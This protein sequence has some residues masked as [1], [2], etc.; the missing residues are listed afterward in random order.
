MYEIDS[1][2]AL[3]NSISKREATPFASHGQLI[4]AMTFLCLL[5]LPLC[6]NHGQ[7]TASERNITD[8]WYVGS[9]ADCDYHDLG[10]ALQVAGG[11]LHPITH[12]EIRIAASSLTGRYSI[13]LDDF[14]EGPTPLE[15]LRIVGGYSACGGS[16]SQTSPRTTLDANGQCCSADH[17]IFTI[18]YDADES[19]AERTVVLENLEMTGG[20]AGE[21]EGGLTFDGGGIRIIGRPGRL[22][23]K[24]INSHVFENQAVISG[25]GGGVYIE[26]TGEEI[27]DDPGNQPPPLLFLDDDSVVTGNV[28]ADL[29]GAI[30]CVDEYDAGAETFALYHVQTGNA[31]IRSNSATHGGGLSLSGCRAV[32]RAGGPYVFDVFNQ[33]FLYSGGV[34]Q[35]SADNRGGGIHAENGAWVVLRGTPHGRWGGVPESAAWIAFNQA[36]RGG[37]L[38]VV[39]EDSTV[40]A[41]DTWFE[42]NTV[43]TDGGS[44]GLGGAIY[45]LNQADVL[46]DRMLL[47]GDDPQDCRMERPT[48]AGIPPRCSGLIGNE[49][50][51]NGAAFYVMNGARIDVRNSF[52]QHN[53]SEGDFGGLSRT[54]NSTGFGGI[55]RAHVRM[56]NTLISGN[57]AEE[58]LIYSGAGGSHELRYSTIAAN[59]LPGSGSL[60]RAFSNDSTRRSLN[61]VLGSILWDEN[62]RPITTGGNEGY[63]FIGCVIGNDDVDDQDNIAPNEY[64]SVIDPEF[65]DSDDGDFGLA[66]TSPA[67]NYCDDSS[68]DFVPPIDHDLDLH[69]RNQI[70]TG[71]ITEPPNPS[72]GRIYDLGAF[73]VI[74]DEVFRDRFETE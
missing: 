35:N 45:A 53:A 18:N 67:I 73:V 5:I 19:D 11:Q 27:V 44:G 46:I 22:G 38:Y 10:T 28:A 49:A 26:T 72:D 62:A 43:A 71:Q 34:L 55:F 15:E 12:L 13:N 23:V 52:V 74:P 39:G 32:I 21:T 64:Y 36:T 33:Q 31:L 69:D 4:A 2:F 66:L 65:I 29:G 40:D 60:V 16:P 24:L 61:D 17:R 7:A 8:I 51:S 37:G 50:E 56:V 3:R 9:S 48:H 54:G 63:T 25:S 42:G 20:F 30:R 14:V 68:G 47:A 6:M 57:E 58:H 1:S 70:F 41:R 59:E